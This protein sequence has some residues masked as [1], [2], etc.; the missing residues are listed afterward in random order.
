MAYW[1][2]AMANQNNRKRAVSFL[3]KAETLRSSLT[4]RE[5][6]W[7]DALAAY[8]KEGSTSEQ[9]REG[10]IHGLEEIVAAY[11]EELE[12][13]AFLA[14]VLINSSPRSRVSV[15]T[16][17]AEILRK[18]PMHPGA[19][20]YRIHLWDG[21]T[22][23]R[24]LQSAESYH[25]AAPGIAHAWHMPGHIYNGL[26]RWK[27][28]SYQ[29]EASARVDHA[30]VAKRGLMPFQIH[31]Y[32]HNQHYLIANLS[33]MGRVRDAVAFSRNL[34]E[35]PRDP[36]RNN[37][38]DRSSAQRLGRASLMRTYVRYERWDDLLN[39]PLLD[40]SDVTEE[41]AWKA[42]SRGLAYL[43][44]G[45]LERARAESSS[46]A[47]IASEAAAKKPPAAGA[48][49][50]EAARLELSGRL[51]V[52][53][54][55]A[56][57]GFELLNKGA[58]LARRF[59]GDLSG[60]P[61]P[62]Y[63]ALG[64][65]HLQARNWGLA[66]ACF[67]RVLQSRKNTLV[68]LAGLVEACA[69]GGKP[70]E[71]R[72]AWREFEEAWKL[73]D[74]DLPFRARLEPL[75]G[76]PAVAAQPATKLVSLAESAPTTQDSPSSPPSWVV[77]PKLGP[78]LWSPSPAA[79]FALK[80]AAGKTRRLEEYRGRNLVLVF[81][82]GG[83]CG[84]CLEQLKALSK[85][86]TA[87]ESLD[88]RIAA[89]SSDSPAQIRELLAAPTGKELRMPLLSDA[90]GEAARRYAAWDEFE[91]FPLHALFLID[92]QGNVRWHRISADPFTDVAFLKEE[93]A[94]INRLTATEGVTR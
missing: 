27:E 35:T 93:L 3:A 53:E 86:A 88:A 47:K 18:A 70:A 38:S 65:V 7:L 50:M 51:L 56:V 69:Q 33:H 30:H 37:K 71:A 91:E 81:Y 84:P 80:D 43:G 15:D 77:D 60:Y 94:R 74:V 11:P 23:G 64:Q 73:A 22:P 42:Y 62:F 89:V 58:E 85:E 19:H 29:Q 41:Q 21:R 67:R 9:Q 31:N 14:G 79:P 39:D 20:H 34:V 28:A 92:R 6:K 12:A 87:I 36:Q 57:E 24:A 1:G 25:Q 90:K 44:K 5:R 75:L 17:I 66:E 52:A 46:L 4:E 55:D 10:F 59:S 26:S 16:L 83:A 61:R 2:M 68:S 54:G 76:S 40:W 63:E 78:K 45:E 13:K 82:L 72:S 32:A 48:D 49:M 8:Y